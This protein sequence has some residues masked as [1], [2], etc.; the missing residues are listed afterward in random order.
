MRL[1][2]KAENSPVH[3]NLN[4]MAGNASAMPGINQPGSSVTLIFQRESK[5]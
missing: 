3:L 5:F 1:K 2:T 4:D